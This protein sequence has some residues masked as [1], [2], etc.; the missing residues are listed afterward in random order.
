MRFNIVEEFKIFCSAVMFFTRLPVPNFKNYNEAWLQKSAKYFSLV[1]LIVGLLVILPLV[2]LNGKLPPILLLLA[3]FTVSIFITGAFHEDGFA[4]IC[5]AF[6]GGYTIAKKLEIMKD[7]R[8]GTYGVIG[9]VTMLA[10]KLSCWYYI[11]Q[12]DPTSI[13]L[14]ILIVVAY[15]CSRY[16]P[17]LVMTILRYVTDDG[18][19]KSKPIAYIGP[20]ILQ[21]LVAL[22]PVVF[23]L[24]W[25]NAWLVW[26]HIVI[27]LVVTTF[28]MLYLFNKHIKGFTGDCLGATQ[29]VCEIAVYIAFLIV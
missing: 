3:T 5:D 4:D 16:T 29:Q 26:W 8:L 7:S 28:F 22:I 20:N 27:A 18:L 12:K 1:G 23:L 10:A 15:T 14:Q 17:L 24:Y 11:L 9:L 19:S 25:F 6:G 21:H 2:L 13:G